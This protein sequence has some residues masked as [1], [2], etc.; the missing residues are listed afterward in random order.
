MPNRSHFSF[1]C[2]Y[3]LATKRESQ[4]GLCNMTCF[5]ATFGLAGQDGGQAVLRSYRWAQFGMYRSAYDLTPCST[6][7]SNHAP[8]WCRVV[9]SG[10][11]H[12]CTAWLQSCNTSCYRLQLW[13]RALLQRRE[14]IRFRFSFLFILTSNLTAQVCLMTTDRQTVLLSHWITSVCCEVNISWNFLLML[15][16]SCSGS[17]TASFHYFVRENSGFMTCLQFAVSVICWYLMVNYRDC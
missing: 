17:T 16:C 4:I 11:S 1:D 5:P 7:A 2:R 9:N 3:C 10:R 15:L 13:Q 6:P 14:P 8:R 12:R